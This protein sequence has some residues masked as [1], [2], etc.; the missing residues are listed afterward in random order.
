MRLR[1]ATNVV[2]TVLIII[3]LIAGFN[4]IEFSPEQ[5]LSE[6]A[7]L[8]EEDEVADLEGGYGISGAHPLAVQAGMDIL[9]AGGNA[10]DAFITTSFMLNVVEPYGSGIGGGGS[11]LYYDPALGAA[12]QY[13]D[14][15]ET[16]PL[17]AG[18]REQ[19]ASNFG[20]P[21]FLIGMST[22]FDS[23]ASG[24]FSFSELIQPAVDVAEAGFEIDRY[25]AG[26]L[27][28]AQYRMNPA[29][30]PH[31]YDNAETIQSGDMLVQE[32]LAETLRTIQETG[33]RAYFLEQLAPAMEARYPGL[34]VA[35][36]QQYQLKQ[37]EPATGTF[38]GFS[39]YSAPA[40]LAGPTLITMLQAAE[41]L[42]LEGEKE[43]FDDPELWYLTY[44]ELLSRLQV[45]AYNDRLQFIADPDFN[46]GDGWTNPFLDNLNR[47]TTDEYAQELAA[48]VRDA[49]PAGEAEE[50]MGRLD[51]R[52]E[53]RMLRPGTASPGL[54][55]LADD[56]PAVMNDHNNTSHFV[57][58]DADGRMI[59]GTH[60]LS[61]FFGSGQ[62]HAG[63]FLNDQLS[64]FNQSPESINRY[65]PGKR[66]R[67]FMA[68]T[69][70]VSEEQ[71]V[72]GIGSPGG[73]R[74]PNMIAQTLIHKDIFSYGLKAAINQ[75][76]FHFD[77]RINRTGEIG[78]FVD[79]RF[80]IDWQADLEGEINDREDVDGWI[81]RE[82]GSD[83][84]FGGIQAMFID[85]ENGLV[86]GGSDPRRGGAWEAADPT[87]ER[88]EEP[89][90]I[91]D[92]ID[93]EEGE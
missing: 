90:G 52:G 47:L 59:S 62:Y 45:E 19:Y 22:M 82:D 40:P 46:R 85:R 67:S 71:G 88:R 14:Y 63:F 80:P 9:E 49:V 86:Y 29:E 34:T 51:I 8:P 13:L 81:V 44:T 50:A 17:Y 84:F 53:K 43:Q 75:P 15:R 58:V 21:G 3:F 83:M 70:L 36:F 5:G 57:I 28:H 20:V 87:R 31:F 24:N 4:E 68:P 27:H 6:D 48:G 78:I 32:E 89:G 1:L 16:A 92:D 79:D 33:A 76:R 55:L 56:A 64:N 7:P 42:E 39:V 12:P 60:T 25:L 65:E 91:F 74:I 93:E 18:T 66:P 35:D 54:R 38:Q 41:Y 23:Y 30:I 61:N 73:A 2:G 77:D 72:L 69:I 10:A 37:T 11:L 26:R